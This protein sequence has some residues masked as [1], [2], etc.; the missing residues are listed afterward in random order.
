MGLSAG[1]VVW[2]GGSSENKPVFENIR[3]ALVMTLQH[4]YIQLN[5]NNH[6]LLIRS[7]I[8]VVMTLVFELQPSIIVSR[9]KH[10]SF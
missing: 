6:T 4:K 3:M 5:G 2:E 8:G 9:C 7:R 1:S 10:A